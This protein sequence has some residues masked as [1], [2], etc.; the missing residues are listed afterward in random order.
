MIQIK[1]LIFWYIKEKTILQI[2]KMELQPGHIVGL[3]G[4]NGSGKTSLLQ[5]LSGLSFPRKGR[6]QVNS[7]SPSQRIPGFLS[8]V[9]FLPEHVY[10]P[11]DSAGAMLANS[12]SFYPAFNP[13]QFYTILEKWEVDSSIPASKLST[14]QQRKLALAFAISCNTLYLFLDEPTSGMDI[15]SKTIFRNILLSCFTEERTILISTQQVRDLTNIMDSLIF[16]D[17]GKCMLC[18]TLEETG[19]VLTFGHSFTK[20]DSEMLL[21]AR[22]GELGY[23]I[24]TRNESGIPGEVDVEMLMKGILENPEKILSLFANSTT[25]NAC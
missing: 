15:P 14:G 7:Y 2:E 25:Q 6:I 21:Y 22:P 24:I 5:L 13:D 20:P 23:D 3:V 11:G 16:L 19:K 9:F 18:E 10:I 17:R 4:K 1:D 8:D 12:A